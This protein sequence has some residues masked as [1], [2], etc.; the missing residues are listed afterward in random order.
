MT[1]LD[2]SA[3]EF[4]ETAKYDEKLDFQFFPPIMYFHIST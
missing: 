1:L 4:W 3:A 2:V